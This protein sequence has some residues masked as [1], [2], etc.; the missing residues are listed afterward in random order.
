MG[1]QTNNRH[2]DLGHG[3]QAVKGLLGVDEPCDEG[4][5]LFVEVL[6]L[7]QRLLQLFLLL[8]RSGVDHVPPPLQMIHLIGQRR[9]IF[10]LIG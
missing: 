8:R 4:V 10:A 2:T 3:F 9:T 6:S 1:E 7:L 5:E